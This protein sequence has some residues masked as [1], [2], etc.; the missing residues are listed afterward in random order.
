MDNL[1]IRD[2]SEIEIK[3]PITILEEV[4]SNKK[5]SRKVQPSK[6]KGAFIQPF[7]TFGNPVIDDDI[8]DEEIDGD[9]GII[10]RRLPMNSYNNQP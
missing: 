8:C 4:K 1:L 6:R 5:A 3:N 7:H 10:S 2:L 9:E